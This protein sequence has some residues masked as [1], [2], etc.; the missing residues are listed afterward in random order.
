MP[1]EELDY[2]QKYRESEKRVDQNPD[3]REEGDAKHP[4]KQENGN[5]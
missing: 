2:Y 4:E 3:R 5:Q 1:L